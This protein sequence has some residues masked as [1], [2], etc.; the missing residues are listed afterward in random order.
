M[1]RAHL[2]DGLEAPGSQSAHSSLSDPFADPSDTSYNASART[3]VRISTISVGEAV[4][5]SRYYDA[6]QEILPSPISIPLRAVL[7]DQVQ[8][9]DLI[10]GSFETSLL[11]LILTAS[12]T[13]STMGRNL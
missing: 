2:G 6:V 9:E 10:V 5:A 1:A 3:S 8:A 7:P 4:V 11:A 13:G 12:D